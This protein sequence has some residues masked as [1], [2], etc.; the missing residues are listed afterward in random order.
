MLS[1]FDKKASMQAGRA[2]NPADRK[3]QLI[4][5]FYDQ[6]IPTLYTSDLNR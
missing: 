4:S 2:N 3:G 5:S 1:M 6:I